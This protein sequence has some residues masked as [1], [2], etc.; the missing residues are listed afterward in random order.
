MASSFPGAPSPETPYKI[1]A[2][3]GSGIH[4]ISNEKR[5][6]S[7]VLNTIEWLPAWPK[8]VKAIFHLG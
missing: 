2:E 1:S 8:I 7:I 3:S 4:S 6:G 5:Q